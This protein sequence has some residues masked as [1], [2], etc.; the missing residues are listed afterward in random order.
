MAVAR[1]GAEA[2]EAPLT[3]SPACPAC[4]LVAYGEAREV[5]GQETWVLSSASALVDRDDL[6]SLD[7]GGRTTGR[8]GACRIHRLKGNSNARPRLAAAQAAFLAID[9]HWFVCSGHQRCDAEFVGG[10][11]HGSDDTCLRS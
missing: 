10:V 8:W 1:E 7:P 3:P 4:S 9:I 2:V 6:G 11:P 5:L